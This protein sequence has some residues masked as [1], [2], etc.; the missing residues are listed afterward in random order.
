MTSFLCQNELYC[1]GHCFLGKLIGD[2]C[3]IGIREVFKFLWL[4]GEN[5][6]EKIYQHR[7]SPTAKHSPKVAVIGSGPAGMSA[8]WR[9]SEMG[10]SVTVF[11]KELRPGGIPFWET[12]RFRFPAERAMDCLM[13]G[14][15]ALGVELRTGIGIGERGGPSLEDLLASGY[16]HIFVATGLAIP[17][18]M[19]VPGEHGS[20]CISAKQLFRMEREA[21][22]DAMVDRF[23]DMRVVV[24]DAGNT[25]MDASRS[26]LRYGANPTVVYWGDNPRSL[27]KEYQAAKSEGVDFLFSVRPLGLERCGAGII[28]S[29]AKRDHPFTVNADFVV[30]A[31]G[32]LPGFRHEWITTDEK[33]FVKVMGK[34]LQTSRPSILAGGDI[35]AKGNVTTAIRDGFRAA[36]EIMLRDQKGL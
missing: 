30:N 14:L 35:V 29:M 9:L 27:P 18:K 10:A 32:A 26:L 17:E 19:G 28:M 23:R 24:I 6:R 11:E 2:D 21:G 36:K 22:V 12:P 5:H 16:D 34:T 20:C 8:A 7:V 31:I 1:R 33:G 13:N 15:A 4:W 3:A 25:A